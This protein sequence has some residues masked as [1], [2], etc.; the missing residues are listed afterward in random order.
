MLLECIWGCACAVSEG[1]LV[2]CGGISFQLLECQSST[3]LVALNHQTPH[4]TTRHRPHTHSLGH[5]PGSGPPPSLGGIPSVPLRRRLRAPALREGP[6]GGEGRCMHGWM[7]DA[8]IERC[9][10]LLPCVSAHRPKHTFNADPTS[11]LPKFVHYRRPACW[12]IGSCARRSP[13]TT[14]S[15]ASS[16]GSTSKSFLWGHACMHVRAAD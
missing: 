16:S 11:I 3:C 13:P 14:T 1:W 2:V 8:C 4:H 6:A 7:D 12:T 9:F 15:S 10:S 5:G